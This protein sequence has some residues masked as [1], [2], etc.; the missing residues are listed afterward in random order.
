ME[1]KKLDPF[2]DHHKRQ[3]TRFLRIIPIMFCHVFLL[4]IIVKYILAKGDKVQVVKSDNLRHVE[5]KISRRYKQTCLT[6]LYIFTNYDTV[7]QFGSNESQIKID[8]PK[9][10]FKSCVSMII[11]VTLSYLYNAKYINGVENLE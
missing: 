1:S 2:V 10:P 3:V 9:T 8:M 6:D 11:D 5:T 4:Y 7:F